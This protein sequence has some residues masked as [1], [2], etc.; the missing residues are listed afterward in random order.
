MECGPP[1]ICAHEHISVLKLHHHA[2]HVC[3][4]TVPRKESGTARPAQGERVG[5]PFRFFWGRLYLAVARVIALF[6]SAAHWLMEMTMS[7]MTSVK[8]LASCSSIHE[9]ECVRVYDSCKKTKKKA[10]IPLGKYW[11]CNTQEKNHDQV[12]KIPYLVTG[13]PSQDPKGLTEKLKPAPPTFT[14]GRAH[15]SSAPSGVTLMMRPCRGAGT[16]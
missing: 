15:P 3:V 13:L 6:R 5:K 16:W 9:H 11:N 10:I 7:P 2:F 4:C 12:R 8:S 1:R 14:H